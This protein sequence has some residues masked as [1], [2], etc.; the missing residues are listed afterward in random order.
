MLRLSLL[1][2]CIT[3]CLLH[4]WQQCLGGCGFSFIFVVGFGLEG[5]SDFETAFGLE[6]YL[7]SDLGWLVYFQAIL[8]DC[9]VLKNTYIQI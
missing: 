3:P 6:D 4:F 2:G 8:Q 7:H 9:T 5:R 1:R